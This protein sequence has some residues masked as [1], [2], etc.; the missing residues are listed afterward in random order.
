MGK[1]VENN[2]GKNENIV[3]KAEL[4]WIS[5]IPTWLGGILFCWLL[6]IPFFNAIITTVKF[7]HIELAVT[8][9]RIIGKAGVVNTSALDAPLNKVQNVSVKENLWGKIL[10]YG[11]VRID[12]AAG[13]YEFYMVKNAN[14]F[15]GM[16]MAQI[17]QYEEDRI[18]Q[19]AAEMANA[20]SA[21]LA[22]DKK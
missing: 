20:M 12:T 19:Q 1:Y 5:L 6:L 3:K 21:A 17:D 15:K 7:F 10:N 11:T 2:L 14:A 22:N 9:K 13:K 4:N 16:V 8:N 18:K